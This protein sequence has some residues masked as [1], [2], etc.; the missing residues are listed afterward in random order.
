MC[1]TVY[2]NTASSCH[3][4]RHFP[5]QDSP[6]CFVVKL[7]YYEHFT[8][9][10][11]ATVST[12]VY[13]MKYTNLINNSSSKV[14]ISKFIQIDLLTCHDEIFG[15]IQMGGWMDGHLKHNKPLQITTRT[16]LTL[17]LFKGL[18]PSYIFQLFW[19]S[20]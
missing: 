19:N 1:H 3:E 17:Y 15:Q 7:L 9:N 2:Q 12:P 5:H 14:R 16:L 4:T 20:V 13:Q 6:I 18:A 11:Q 8:N 10:L